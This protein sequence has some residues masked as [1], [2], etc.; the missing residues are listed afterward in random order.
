MYWG[1]ALPHCTAHWWSCRTVLV[2]GYSFVTSQCLEVKPLIVAIVQGSSASFQS[3]Y[4]ARLPK[5]PNENALRDKGQAL[6]KLK[7]ITSTFL[8]VTTYPVISPWRAIT[9]SKPDVPLVNPC[10]MF[11]MATLSFM[12][13][14]WSPG[15]LA[16]WSHQWLWRGW[17]ASHIVYQILSCLH[18]RL[19]PI[20]RAL[21]QP[22]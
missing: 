2:T 21:L 16:A 11:L 9:W 10:W 18:V 12:C 20:M 17:L 4:P 6:L 5:F 14:E 1:C 3:V 19:Y 15:G 8:H 22:P 13:L 7:Y